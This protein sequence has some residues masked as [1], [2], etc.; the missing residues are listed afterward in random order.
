MNNVEA[1]ATDRRRLVFRKAFRFPQSS[2]PKPDSRNENSRSQVV[3]HLLPR[4]L[5]FLWR[6]ALL[7]RRQ[8]ESVP[9]FDTVESGER[10][11]V[12]IRLPPRV[13]AR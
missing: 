11:R 13:G 8:A 3:F 10:Q 4:G 9:Q 7:K 12:R 2:V 6:Q 1:P 5:D